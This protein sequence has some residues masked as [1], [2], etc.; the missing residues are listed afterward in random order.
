MSTSERTVVAD[1]SPEALRADLDEDRRQLA[2][3]GYESRFDRAMSLWANFSLGFTY[4][5]PVVGIYALFAV[6]LATAG[7]PSVWSLLIA[8]AGQFLVA[9][10]FAEVVSQFPI[11]GG[12]YAWSR[13]LI[14]KR[15]AWMA[16]WIYIWALL[17]TIASVA[18]GAGP[19]AASLL[20]VEAS[21][22]FVVGCGL[23]VLALAAIVNFSGTR[24]LSRAAQIGFVAEITGALVIGL[25]LILFQRE[26]DFG[27]FFDGFGTAGDGTYLGAFLAASL[28]GLYQY[29]GFE[30]CGDVAEE[31][32]DPGRRIPRAMRWT[33]LVGGAVATLVFV[34]YSVA[35]PDMDAVIAGEVADPISA[36]LVDTLGN[37]GSKV[38]LVIVLV[39]FLSC[40]LSLQAAASRALYSYGRDE[41]IVGSR[42]L[43]RFSQRTHV[44]PG[45]LTVAGLIPALVVAGSL[46]SEDALVRIISFAVL[47]IYIA[48]QMVVLAALIARLRGWRPRGKFTLG[49][50]GLP[51]NVT[52]LV[53]GVSASVNVAWPRSPELPWYDNWIV[54]LGSAVVVGAGVLYMALARPWGRSTAPAG[55]A[56]PSSAPAAERAAA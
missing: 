3:L 26:N 49:R 29:Y 1:V 34:G 55:D 6:A 12:V 16:G 8:G 36:V 32:P 10:V 44:P 45:A 22:G 35:I 27:I 21:T 13:R 37:G 11:A 23:V 51:V 18:Y 41:M 17:F 52:A 43:G 40:V 25:Y 28:I 24:N 50:W 9:L 30:A 42:Y 4:L 39:S 20:G 53:Y 54:L 31:V 19:F 33:I 7:P 48:F 2:E 5:S 14:G 15:Y 56:I 47:G 38:F 46:I